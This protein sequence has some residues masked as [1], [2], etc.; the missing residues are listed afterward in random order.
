MN[1]HRPLKRHPCHQQCFDNQH[2]FAVLPQAQ[3]P[4]RGTQLNRVQGTRHMPR[5]TNYLF[6]GS[7]TPPMTGTGHS[8]VEESKSF[9]ILMS[10]QITAF[11]ATLL[12]RGDGSAFVHIRGGATETTV[13]TTATQPR[14]STMQDYATS[15]D[16]ILQNLTMAVGN[17]SARCYADAPWRAFTWVCLCSRRQAHNHGAP[18]K[19]LFK[20]P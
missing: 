13:S 16:C 18:C 20:S 12:I 7:S 19:T 8:L 9:S 3:M 2:R 17:P 5:L 15:T 1:G 14:Q 6:L 10:H 11:L 4:P